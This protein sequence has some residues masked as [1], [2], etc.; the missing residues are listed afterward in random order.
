MECPIFFG[1]TFFHFGTQYFWSIKF[2]F[3][4]MGVS[5]LLMYEWMWNALFVFGPTFFHFGTQYFW[6]Y[7]ILFHLFGHLMSTKRA[8]KSSSLVNSCLS[9]C[10]NNALFVFGPTFFHF[11]T[12]YFFKNFKC[13][14]KKFYS[15][16]NILCFFS[17]FWDIRKLFF[18]LFCNL[19]STNV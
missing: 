17:N 14:L 7:Q 18:Q 2:F 1:P 3:I 10:G 6:G 11:G 8:L 15:C 5:C 13:Y 19:V 9:G 12:Q 4:C 16:F